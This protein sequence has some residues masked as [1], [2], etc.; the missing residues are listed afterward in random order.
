[1]TVKGLRVIM[2]IVHL[3]FTQGMHVYD[4]DCS[5]CEIRKFMTDVMMASN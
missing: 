2:L 5:N 3:F 4:S 1:M